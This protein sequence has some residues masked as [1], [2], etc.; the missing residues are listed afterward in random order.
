M[1]AVRAHH[2]GPPPR[3]LPVEHGHRG[4]AGV[5]FVFILCVQMCFFVGCWCAFVLY[6]GVFAMCRG[7]FV[8]CTSARI[9]K[10]KTVNQKKGRGCGGGAVGGHRDLKKKNTQIKRKKKGRGGGGGAVGG[11][12]DFPAAAGPLA[13]RRGHQR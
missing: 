4:G 2:A 9:A 8:V 11:H 12:R 6:R 10:N 13:R 7:V 1:L 3:A 5:L